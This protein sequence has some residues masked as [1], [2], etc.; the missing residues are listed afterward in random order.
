MTNHVAE[1][2][3]LKSVA[4]NNTTDARCVGK[5][6]FSVQFS[7]WITIVLATSATPTTGYEM[8]ATNCTINMQ[9]RFKAIN[10]RK[11]ISSDIRP[12]TKDF[13][14]KDTIHELVLN[15]FVE[16]LV[17]IAF[18]ISYSIVFY[19]P[20]HNIIENVGCGYW[21]FKKSKI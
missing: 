5:I 17:P 7:L 1:K 6:S 13:Q 12:A 14:R 11:Q 9:L 16:T 2:I 8:L 15:E 3:V 4:D 10:F 21:S 20:N 18:I 19:G